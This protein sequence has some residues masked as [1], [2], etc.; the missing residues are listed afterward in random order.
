MKKLNTILLALLICISLFTGCKSAP[1]DPFDGGNRYEQGGQM[2]DSFGNYNNQ[3]DNSISD[4]PDESFGEALEDLGVNDGYFDGEK[5]DIQVEYISG[6]QNAYSLNG[7]VL[8]FK[9]ISEDSVYSVSGQFNGNI[10]IDIGDEHKLELELTGL[11]LVSSQDVP[12]LILSGDKVTL[13]AKKET[14]NY[15]YDKRE[16]V[17]DADDSLIK[18][19]IHSDVDLQI[20]GKGAL[21]VVSDNYNGIHSKDDLEVKNLTLTV[22]CK[23]NALKGNDGVTL[24]DGVVTL[25][26]SQGDGIKTTGSDIS[27]K[28]NQRGIVSIIGTDITIYA[29]CDGIDSAYDTVIDGETTVLN[30]YTDKYS[31]YSEEVTATSSS[32]YY[33]RFSSDAYKYSVKYFNSDSDYEWA[34]AVY[35]STASGGRMKYYYYSFPKKTEYSKMQFFIY[36]SD[37]E[38]GQEAEYLAA[39][40]GLTPNETYDTFALENRGNSL[41]YSWT[42]YTTTVQEG[43]M[44]GRPGGMG[45]FGGMG[46]GNSDKGDHSTKGIKAANEITV[47]NGFVNIKSYDDSLHADNTTTLENGDAPLGNITVNGGSLTLYSNDDGIHAEGTVCING[48][49]VNVVNSYEGVEGINVVVTG[50]NTSVIAKDDGVNSTATSGTGVTLS[51]G[52]VYIYCSGDGIDANSRSSY[53][54]ISFEGGDAVIISNSGGNSAIDTEQGYKY[55]SGSIVAIMPRGGM[56]NEATHC[57]NFSSIGTST[58]TSLSQGSDLK[59]TGDM[60]V[61]VTM[62]CSISNGIV[63]ILNKN[64]EVSN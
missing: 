33:I 29:A 53:S 50:G 25:I 36:S 18:G 55:T 16:A 44:G 1:K 60:N 37:M 38:Q 48:G 24:T 23:D 10:I 40:D 57:S 3:Q 28:G 51:G 41:T 52:Y 19:A 35:H 30:I 13:T 14:E 59:I 45:G 39:S 12:V 61:T 32:E 6:T 9:G 64:V 47:N 42:N 5:V 7:N 34:N 15:I 31:S 27:S 63:I 2:G 58:T 56:T 46:E 43:G 11:S 20:G 54:G 8:T 62:P 21:T 22:T 17:S 26:A 4:D 49:N